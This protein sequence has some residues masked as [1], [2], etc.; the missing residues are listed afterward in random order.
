[1]T[2]LALWVVVLGGFYLLL[3]VL[4]SERGASPGPTW[5]D[6]APTLTVSKKK[7]TRGEVDA[8]GRTRRDRDRCRTS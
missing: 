3:E 4:C 8:S 6:I 2:T 5:F 7:R 1:M